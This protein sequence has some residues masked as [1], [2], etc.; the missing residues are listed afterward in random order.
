MKIIPAPFYL[1]L[2]GIFSLK[3]SHV[4]TIDILDTLLTYS[5]L[6]VFTSEIMLEN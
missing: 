3:Y 5:F 2:F 6:Y 4:K 1:D